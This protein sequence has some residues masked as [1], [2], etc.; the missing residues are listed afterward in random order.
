MFIDD[1]IG[2]RLR[3]EGETENMGVWTKKRGFMKAVVLM[4]T[5]CPKSLW[6]RGELPRSDEVDERETLVCIKKTA[7]RHKR[8]E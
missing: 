6:Q 7:T 8:G 2:E 1:Y 4:A 3:L 5:P